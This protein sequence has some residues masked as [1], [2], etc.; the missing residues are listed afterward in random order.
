LASRNPGS[1]VSRGGREGLRRSST[2]S[3]IDPFVA[4]SSSDEAA[5]SA[6]RIAPAS[7]ALDLRHLLDLPDGTIADSDRSPARRSGI[8][9]HNPR[10]SSGNHHHANPADDPAFLRKRTA[11]LL[12]LPSADAPVPGAAEAPST[13]SSSSEAGSA[14][15]SG[16]PRGFKPDKKTFHFLMDAWAFSSEPDA[17]DQA[18][19]LLDKMELL[20]LDPDVRSYTKAMNAFGRSAG[21][22]DAGERAAAIFRR[23]ASAR[24]A[25]VRPNTHSYTAVVEAHAN[26]GA[27][28]SAG[29]ADEWCRE[30]VRAYRG[31]DGGAVP[32]SRAFHA[33]ITGYAKSGEPRAGRKAQEAF[34]LME[35]MWREG[36]V[37]GCRPT[38][39]NYNAL[40]TAWANCPDEPGSARQARRLLHRMEELYRL[41]DAHVK[42]TT[43]TFNAVIDAYAK[44]AEGRSAAAAEGDGT[45]A[46]GDGAESAEGQAEEL[47]RHMEELHRTGENADARPNVRSFNS[48]LNV[49]AKSGR[50]E[51]ADRAQEILALMEN[52]YQK[53]NEEVRPDVHSFCTVIN[54]A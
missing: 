41:G 37:E 49:W 48:V 39:F 14:P 50:D 19:A 52:L 51:G 26:S 8:H 11:S 40:I 38:G 20:G 36:G 17:A 29:L 9:H 35:R 10:G 42:P 7:E 25:S 31:G 47:L 34:D 15:S 6:L 22:H 2:P 13:S 32:T 21:R 44:A 45:D 30:M 54:G 46:G 1:I 16:H 12:A 28:G 33:V 18:A 24:G 3:S 27:P 5:G 53:G 43:V 4:A 23:M